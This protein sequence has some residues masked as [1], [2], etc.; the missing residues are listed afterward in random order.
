LDDGAPWHEDF[1]LLEGNDRQHP[2]G[3]DQFSGIELKIWVP[4]VPKPL[5]T[6][7]ERLIYQNTATREGAGD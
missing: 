1:P 3:F 6:E 5:V 7:G 2:K 4:R